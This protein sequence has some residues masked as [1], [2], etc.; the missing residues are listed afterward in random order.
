MNLNTVFRGPATIDP[1]RVVVVT[2]PA[3]E[4]WTS[5]DS[6]VQ[7]AFRLD[8]DDDTDFVDLAIQS[9]R[10][11]FERITGLALIR[12][13]LRVCY[14]EIP[15]RQGQF[16]LEYGLA[17]TMSRF[18]GTAAGRELP[19]ARSPLLSVENVKYLDQSGALTVW[20]ASNYTEGNVGVATT[21]GRIWLNEDTD[22]PDVGSF[23]GALQVEFFAGFG[24]KPTD[25]PP[26]IRM[27]V[28]QLAIHWYENRLPVADGLVSL[29]NHLDALITAHRL[30]FT[31]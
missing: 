28:L 24:D 26:D 31:A 20:D 1:P 18:T 22:W 6:I 27:A 14:D 9:A 12:Q 16:G 23:P 13:Q 17:P 25:I 5:S 4:P 7:Q 29:P 30:S 19:L 2:P 3:A 15:L 8:S 11:Y 21:A 10:A